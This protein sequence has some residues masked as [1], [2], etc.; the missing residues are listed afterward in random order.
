MPR[1]LQSLIQKA[2]GGDSHDRV[3]RDL[4]LQVSIFL[5][6]SC[7]LI[8]KPLATSLL[9]SQYGVE[10]MPIAYG[11]IAVA[12]VV[13]HYAL[14]GVS[15]RVSTARLTIGNLIVQA[16]IFSGI[17]ILFLSDTVTGAVS[18]SLYV[19]ISLF[20][21]LTVSYFYQYCQSLL[22][23]REAKKTLSRVAAAAI[24]GG[25]F[26]GYYAFVAVKVMGNTGLICTCVVFL[27]L[28]LI[29]LVIVHK[30]FTPQLQEESDLGKTRA[31]RSRNVMRVPH[32]RMV[33][34]IIGLGVVVAKLVDYQFNYIAALHFDAEE[35]LTS[36]FGF[37]YSTL[38]I[39]GL[40]LQIFLTKKVIDRLGITV[41]MSLMP[42]LL[43][44]ATIAMII[45]PALLCA[46]LLKTAEGSLKQSL[47]KTSTEINIMPIAAHIRA[48]VKTFVDV[49]VD[50]LASGV[51]G[52]L[53]YIVIN[54]M[55]LPFWMVAVVNG[56]VMIAWL[57][58]IYLS[59]R[60]YIHQLR[61]KILN[62]DDLQEQV[63]DEV[64]IRASLRAQ[65][66]S[67]RQRN[68]S[69]DIVSLM[70]H[71][72][73]AVR[74]SALETY[75]Q[76]RSIDAISHDLTEQILSDSSYLVRRHY[77]WNQLS[78]IE[79]TE[80][81]D[82]LYATHTPVNQYVLTAAL[83]EA[84]KGH[85]NK[86]SKYQLRRRIKRRWLDRAFIQKHPMA[87][88]AIYRAILISGHRDYIAEVGDELRLGSP[89][90]PTILR[91]V[92]IANPPSFF[93]IL[94]DLKVEDAI[95]PL[96]LKALAQYTPRL[97]QEIKRT[98][99]NQWRSMILLMPAL[100]HRPERD[101]MTLLMDLL[102]H[103]RL[104]VRRR[105]MSVLNKIRIKHPEL[106]YDQSLIKRRFSRELRR[107]RV[108]I[109]AQHTIN[110]LTDEQWT[111]LQ[112]SKKSTRTQL[113]KHRRSLTLSIFI[114][115]GLMTRRDDIHLVYYA[116]KSGKTDEVLDYLDQILKYRTR[117]RV[118]PLLESLSQP[119]EMNGYAG[120]PM[121]VMKLRSYLHRLMQQSVQAAV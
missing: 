1:T 15:R 57:L 53:I 40:L 28:S 97:I 9:L 100:H 79:T 115:L 92:R 106:D 78:V 47:Y 44:L 63:L 116:L 87:R 72:S 108:M 91:A 30:N 7:L 54:Q 34:L 51:A 32:A 73:A 66:A 11:V 83:A 20:A 27:L 18:F 14:R 74:S 120:R 39:I 33:A 26:G 13:F 38:N 113:R 65:D 45:T 94:L 76:D 48:K 99:S 59:R 96:W 16:V 31:P 112:I 86:M 52:V 119:H 75:L 21:L 77:L 58:V 89:F 111:L 82:E 50:S 24:A 105:A 81:L 8:V 46:I 67:R 4:L 109:R 104:A 101:T 118:V 36:F 69:D 110:M 95:R 61:K 71:T 70:E 42:V 84:V 43:L 93:P 80:Q 90:R 55:D 37:W 22:T 88:R 62:H 10:I 25:V 103:P 41:S 5:V 60:T 6:I 56:L 29:A 35:V 85:K 68:R 2:Y 98:E 102:Q 121:S 3:R 19:Y 12:A 117:N 17:A 114:M 23:I 64:E 49:V 107:A